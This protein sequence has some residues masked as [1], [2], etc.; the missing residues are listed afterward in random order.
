MRQLPAPFKKIIS[1]EN[2]NVPKSEGTTNKRQDIVIEE[3][4]TTSKFGV[5]GSSLVD[6]NFLDYTYRNT[7]RRYTSISLS[8]TIK[9]VHG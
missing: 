1:I 8:E 9:L 2:Q 6:L 5:Q 4:P 7:D 3:S